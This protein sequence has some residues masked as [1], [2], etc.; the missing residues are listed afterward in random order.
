MT[1]TRHDNR[2]ARADPSPAAQLKLPQLELVK[3]A[4]LT[5]ILGASAGTRLEASGVLARGDTFYVIF[6]NSPHI[7]RLD[8]GCAGRCVPDRPAPSHWRHRI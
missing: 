8:G 7:A 5:E 1:P 2:A 3:E 4:K 6:D